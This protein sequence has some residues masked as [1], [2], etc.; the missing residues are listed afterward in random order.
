MNCKI[1]HE[2]HGR[3]RVRMLMKRMTG[4][5]ADR[6]HYYLLAQEGVMKVTVS[7]RTMDATILFEPGA[8]GVRD[9]VVAA[10]ASFDIANSPVD[11]PDHTGRELN[12][13][14]EDKLFFLV[15]RRAVSLFILPPVLRNLVCLTKAAHYIGSGLKCLGKGRLEVPVLDAT[16]ISVSILR[17]N[18]STAGSVMF[19]LDAGSLLEEWTHKKSVDDLARR[20]YINVDSAWVKTENAGEVLMPVS[21]IVPDDHVIVRTGNVIPLDGVVAAGEGAV[22]QAS[23]TGESLPVRKE[24]GAYVYAGTVLEEGELEI[25][26]KKA[27]GSGRYDKIIHMIEESEKLKSSTEARAAHLADSLVPWSLGGSVV[28]WLLTRNAQRALAFLMVDF[29]CALKL[30]MPISVLSAMRECSDHHINVKGGKFLEAVSAADT[31]VFDKTG[32]LTRATPSVRKVV[33]FGSHDENE[34]LRLAACLEEHFPHSIANAVVNEAKNRGLVHE[35]RHTKVEYVVAHGIASSINGVRALI[36]SYHFIFEDEKAEM[37][38]DETDLEHFAALPDDCSLLYLSLD[39]KLA[40]VI[41]IEDPIREEAMRVVSDLHD[42]GFTRVVMMTGD[43]R[44]T[45]A[46]VAERLGMDEFYAEVLPEDKAAFIRKE[47]DAGRKVVMIGDGI[48][49]SPALS[50]ADAGV[51]IAAGAAIA[52]EIA[53]ITISADHL[54]KLIILRRISN[55]LMD[56]IDNNYRRIMLFNG[57]LIALGFFGV[58]PP[59]TSALCHN[60]STIYFSLDSMKNLL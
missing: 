6:L 24:T 39:G 16:T 7:E 23:M 45:A 30:A 32:T 60:V 20:M 21:K 37:P 11:V 12:R 5:Q 14:F 22:N 9:T 8:E 33:A 48:N 50:E 42:A 1:L 43:S 18:W 38:T 54:Q 41:C 28:T 10:L 51:A 40:A 17:G 59:A 46:A 2:T 44:K 57:G 52:R 15:A 27:L 49:D 35:E 25:C 56:R 29:S 13:D 4:A 31:I 55:R 58:I 47:H 36:G 3:M 34:M 53:D 26:V 19:L